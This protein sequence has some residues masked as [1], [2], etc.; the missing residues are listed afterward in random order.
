MQF[1]HIIMVYSVLK[2]KS[3]IFIGHLQGHSKN[4]GILWSMEKIICG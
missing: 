3:V 2:M 1:M 4:F